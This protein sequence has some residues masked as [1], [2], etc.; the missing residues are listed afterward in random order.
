V[1]DLPRRKGT[2][3][4]NAGWWLV[5][6][7]RAMVDAALAARSPAL[8]ATV[9]GLG[10]AVVRDHRPFLAGPWSND[11]QMLI[12]ALPLPER[13]VGVPPWTE[14][15]CRDQG[16]RAP[17]WDRRDFTAGLAGL[18][19][20]TITLADQDGQVRAD[21]GRGLPAW[22]IPG[23]A[24]RWFAAAAQDAIARDR[25]ARRSDHLRSA[26][27]PVDLRDLAGRPASAGAG[28]HPALAALAQ[29][30]TPRIA[31]LAERWAQE[32]LPLA[33]SSDDD[34]P[35]V[36][37]RL[38]AAQAGDLPSVDHR[39]AVIAAAVERLRERSATRSLATSA[40]DP[41]HLAA[42]KSLAVASVVL[43]STGDP[44][45]VGLAERAKAL[46][47][48]A[49]LGFTDLLMS[50]SIDGMVDQTMVL[51]GLTG[52]LGPA[53]LERWLVIPVPDVRTAL[54]QA[55]DGERIL[56]G[57]EMAAGMWPP[58][59][60]L[61]MPVDIRAWTGE[62]AAALARWYGTPGQ[63]RPEDWVPRSR[64]T[65]IRMVPLDIVA[66]AAH[67]HAAR[68]HLVRLAWRLY[69]AAPGRPPADAA[70]AS[71]LLGS[72]LV[73]P[74]PGGDLPLTYERRGTQGFRLAVVAAP[75]PDHI[76]EPRWMRMTARAPDEAR[77]VLPGSALEIVIT[78]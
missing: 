62:D 5:G 54:D 32:P 64:L 11:L 20:S 42:A 9:A 26:G 7:E 16:W 71:A 24:L 21:L 67:R 51:A 57:H 37:A 75:M 52:A 31:T 36:L 28:V 63:P 59:T 3:A 77:L 66:E 65:V 46:A 72:P 69:A 73:V 39:Q 17:G 60:S 48:G 76:A 6:S 27:I 34:D 61:L 55:G 4:R 35:L 45:A 14:Q 8:S 13:L 15:V 78:P 56:I 1:V 12:A 29:A 50:Q 30:D 49:P 10:W 22:I 44:A 40:Y 68:H 53:G 18:P 58:V 41:R 33:A 43:A 2:F 19:A 23:A 74:W 70:A 38:I 25:W 47:A